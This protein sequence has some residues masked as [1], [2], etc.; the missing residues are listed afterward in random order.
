MT[1]LY[2]NRQTLENTQYLHLS[3]AL[4]VT[5][6]RWWCDVPKEDLKELK[7]LAADM[8]PK[9]GVNAMTDGN[10]KML[11][12][13]DDRALARRLLDMAADIQ[14]TFR[15]RSGFTLKEARLIQRATMVELQLCAPLRTRNLACLEIGPNVFERGG[16]FYVHIPAEDVKNYVPLDF[17]LDD[18]CAKI[19]RF[20]IAKVRPLLF[21]GNN[22]FLWPG[23]DGK[24]LNVN[25]V[26][27]LLG[28]F[29][30]DEVG[31][32]VTAHRFRHVA[33]YLYLLDN[34][35]GFE[36]VRLMLG[37][38]SIKTTM[39]FYASLELKEAQKRYDAARARRRRELFPTKGSRHD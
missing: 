31:V 30:E 24:H 39:S 14:R 16:K 15:R 26:G 5:I 12:H 8:K 37:H 33:G 9:A 36:V 22:T 25:Y 20:Y 6:G 27:S 2:A 34:P 21:E 11:R 18:H 28:S 35:N 7:K 1:D 17:E 3:A 32:R 19:L 38:R 29:M 13:F 10:R 4:L 23:S